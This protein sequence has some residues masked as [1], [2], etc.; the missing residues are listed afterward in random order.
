LARRISRGKF[1]QIGGNFSSKV[2]KMVPTLRVLLAAAAISVF[3]SSFAGAAELVM[4]DVAWCSYCAKVRREVA[5][6][7]GET[8][9][10]KVAPLRKVSPLKSWPQDL[11][12]VTPAPFTPV[13]I[14]V[15]RGR[16]IGR[17]MG[18]T[19]AAAVWAKLNPLLSRL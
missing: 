5:P 13:F 12:A 8:A 7:Y 6:S 17:F 2:K 3:T 4:V 15:D 19:D 9:A 10:G 1:H 14:L 18:Y 11:A 16:E